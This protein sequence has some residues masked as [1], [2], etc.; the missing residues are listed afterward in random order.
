MGDEIKT[1]RLVN[2][3]ESV[4]RLFEYLLE[5]N[6]G[7]FGHA[8]FDTAIIVIKADPGTEKI[9]DTP[10]RDPELAQ[11]LVNVCIDYIERYQHGNP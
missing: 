9:L 2:I 11:L 3:P 4:Y 1:D 8:W 10:E 5:R 7:D 6:G